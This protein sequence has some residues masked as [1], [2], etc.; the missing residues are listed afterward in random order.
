MADRLEVV[1]D[2]GR[3][4]LFRRL[5]SE[6]GDLMRPLSER[7][8]EALAYGSVA[9]GDV[10]GGSD[11]D[12]FVPK[13]PSP[14]VLEAI[15]ERAGIPITH[16][17]IV[18]ATPT[19]A[20]KGYV[21]VEENRGYSFPLVDLRTVEREFYSF[22]GSVTL[23]QI[24]GG[25]RVPGVDKRLMLIEPTEAGHTESPVTGREGTVAKTLGIGVTAVLDR[26]RTLRRRER[27][28]RT[29]LYLQR[30]LA[31]GESFGDVY[32]QLARRRPPL[33]RRM[34]M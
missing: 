34:R 1:Y 32:R 13:P 8:L 17:E 30:D 22:A 31:P 12:V 5:R 4:A 3:W 20:A 11:V 28:G 7:H 33:R 18:Q 6:A 29:G 21:Y 16:R 25:E 9:R 24:E 2:E 27:V 26:V 19:Y 14:T 23:G 15:I 10:G